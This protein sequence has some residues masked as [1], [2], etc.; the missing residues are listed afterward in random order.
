MDGRWWRDSKQPPQNLFSE[1]TPPHASLNLSRRTSPLVPCPS[2]PQRSHLRS[3]TTSALRE[4][5][6]STLYRSAFFSLSLS[7]SLSLW[8]LEVG[9]WD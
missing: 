9:T 7:L 2:Q 1:I 4:E 8:K 3:S 6:G 5:R